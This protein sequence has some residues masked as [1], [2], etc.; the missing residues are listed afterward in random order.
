MERR[1]NMAK[2]IQVNQELINIEDIRKVDILS[3]DIYLGLFPRNDEE[4]IDADCVPFE[5]A[6]IHTFGGDVIKVSMDLFPPE[7]DEIEDSWSH[8]NRYYFNKCVAEIMKALDITKVDGYE[9][10]R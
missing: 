4:I 2:F 6:A 1:I 5:I 8:R 7:E 9:Y 10:D 3:D